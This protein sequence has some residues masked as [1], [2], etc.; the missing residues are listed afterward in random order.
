MKAVNGNYNG[1]MKYL[2][3]KKFTVYLEFRE[4][5]K[6]SNLNIWELVVWRRDLIKWRRAIN[7]KG[8]RSLNCKRG[9]R[10][11]LSRKILKSAC[12]ALTRNGKP[13][14]CHNF[15]TSVFW[16]LNILHFKSF[17]KSVHICNSKSSK[18]MCKN[19]CVQKSF[20]FHI[21]WKTKIRPLWG[22][23]LRWC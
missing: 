23:I 14:I 12:S 21:H 9:N 20:F 17:N 11:Q 16:C 22:K 8:R 13:H 2:S 5:V 19:Y 4:F 6:K 18:D 15:Y 10:I 1:L 3:K 7:R